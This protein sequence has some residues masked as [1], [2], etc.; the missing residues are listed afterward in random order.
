MEKDANRGRRALLFVLDNGRAH[1]KALFI[2]HL[3][4]TTWLFAHKD[5]ATASTPAASLKPWATR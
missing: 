4:Q 3:P 5:L 1:E 2:H